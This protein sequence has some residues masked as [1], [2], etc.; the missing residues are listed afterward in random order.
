MARATPVLTTKRLTLS[1]PTAD[2][3]DV[4]FPFVYGEPGRVVTDM[5]LWDGPENIEEL[6]DY[7]EA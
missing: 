3:A 2:D 5:L 7:Y 1:A 4:I 6:R